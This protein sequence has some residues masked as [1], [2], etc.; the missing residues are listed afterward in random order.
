MP[1][2]PRYH[3][4]VFINCPFDPAYAALFDAIVFAV[5]D[6]GYVARSALE[7]QD[8]GTTR[9]DRLLTLI[10]ECRF[11][12]HDLSRTELDA[13]SGLPRFNMPLELGLFLGAQ[14]YGTRRNREKVTLILD[15]ERYRYQRFISD[16]AGQDPA[17][18]AGDPAG[19]ITC[20]RN[21]LRS[22]SEAAIPGAAR[23]VDRYATFR[24]ELPTIC[25]AADLDA[26]ALTFADYSATVA[27][28]LGAHS[29]PA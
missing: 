29:R 20:V 17:A 7:L 2:P 9:L 6:C 28:W 22:H 16:I 13:D 14:H 26:T 27:T 18:H 19:A 15:V 8:S 12:I 11:G 24:R 23:I 25:E 4:S 5:H 10:G 21:W 3:E 1:S